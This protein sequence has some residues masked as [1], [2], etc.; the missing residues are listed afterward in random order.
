MLQTNWQIYDHYG[1]ALIAV[2]GT[3][4]VAVAIQWL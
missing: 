4:A 3:L 2:I 1:Y